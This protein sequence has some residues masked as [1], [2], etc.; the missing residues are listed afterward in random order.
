MIFYEM[1][2]IT[3]H[4]DLGQLVCHKFV[5]DL[6]CNNLKNTQNEKEPF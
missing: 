5:I 2:L 3:K 6:Y 1:T 4:I